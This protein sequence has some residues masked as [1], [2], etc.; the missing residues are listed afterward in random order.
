MNDIVGDDAESDPT[1]DAVRSSVEG[2]PQAMPPFENTDAAFTA[3][4]PFLKI[5]EPPLLVPLFA[6]GTLGVVA[7]DRDPPD[8]RLLG[9]GFV[10]G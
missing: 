1:S 6:S 7:R 10:S 3:C 2:S 5:S 4:A 8:P 9:L